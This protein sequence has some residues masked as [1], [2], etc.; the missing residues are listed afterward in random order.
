MYRWRGFTLIELLVVIAVIGILASTV[1]VNFD[2]ARE[3]ARNNAIMSELKEIQLAVEI[4]RAQEGRYPPAGTTGNPAC[5]DTTGNPHTAENTSGTC[6]DFVVIEGLVPEYIGGLPESRDSGNPNCIFEYEVEEDGGWYK[7]LAEFC[8]DGA[9]QPSEGI[10]PDTEFS[11][12]PTNCIT[13][14]DSGAG[15]WTTAP[16]FY[17]SMAV[18]SVGGECE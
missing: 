11:R 9:T 18:Y 1:F 6:R 4:Y 12:C 3:T 14:G 8:F 17:Q 13:C 15:A 10:Q 7:M 5:Y 16:D 2:G